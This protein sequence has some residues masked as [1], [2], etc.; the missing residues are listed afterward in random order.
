VAAALVLMQTMPV[1]P[2]ELV[3]P[4]PLCGA[5]CIYLALGALDAPVPPFAEFQKQLG[6][7]PSAGFSLGELAEVAEGL[8][9]QTLGVQ[10]TCENLERRPGRF[11]CIA[12]LARG[13]FVLL[14]DVDAGAVTLVDPPKTS[15]VAP[16][17]LQTQWDG[18]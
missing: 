3:D 18:T 5:Y 14:S 10:T 17:V 4:D 6:E 9:M 7:P 16:E 8:G 2:L 1:Q 13:H 12:Y 15:T 11:A